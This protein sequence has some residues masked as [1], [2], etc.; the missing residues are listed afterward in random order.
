MAVA[1]FP[2]PGR[3]RLHVATVA[4]AVWRP[5]RASGV[6]VARVLR[7][8]WHGRWWFTVCYLAWFLAA[9]IVGI[10][11]RTTHL[12]LWVAAAAWLV[13]LVGGA[14]WSLANPFT[15][16]RYV[17]GPWRRHGWRRWARKNWDEL[18]RECGLSVQRT[19]SRR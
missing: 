10:D 6:F 9:I 11:S 2:S 5:L 19:R 13:P 16:D 8:L 15:F 1:T 3:R 12:G 17:A 14:W 18:A 7:A 4:G